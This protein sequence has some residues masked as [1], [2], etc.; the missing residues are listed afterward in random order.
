VARLELAGRNAD[1]L[2]RLDGDLAGLVGEAVVGRPARGPGPVAV[3]RRKRL[4][5]RLA[6]EDD[7]HFLLVEMGVE[8][9]GQA[10]ARRDPVVVDRHF[11]SFERFGETI[12]PDCGVGFRLLDG[13]DSGPLHGRGND[14]RRQSSGY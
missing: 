10:V 3:P 5:G 12:S 1:R 9:R 8:P 6:L 14:A 7:E 13:V 2:S 4:E 11:V